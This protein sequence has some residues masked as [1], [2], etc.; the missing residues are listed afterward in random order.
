MPLGRNRNDEDKE[1]L[2]YYTS[3]LFG[4]PWMLGLSDGVRYDL[5]L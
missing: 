2:D 5:V 1:R 3:R 4:A